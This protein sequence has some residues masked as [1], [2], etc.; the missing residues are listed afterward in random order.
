MKFFNRSKKQTTRN[1]NLDADAGGYVFRR[2]RTL[3]GTTSPKVASSASPRSQL[4]TARLQTHELHQLRNR[5][6][7][8]LAVL[9]I[10]IVILSWLVSTYVATVQIRSL[11]PGGKLA[12][13]DYQNTILDYK[14]PLERF[15]F[16]IN[17]KQLAS[18]MQTLHPEIASIDVDNNW[19]GGGTQ[20]VAQFR[21]PVLAWETGGKRFYVDAKG[22]AFQYDHFGGSYVSV[23]DQSGISPSVSGGTVASN[24]FIQFLGKMVGA[25]NTGGK[26]SVVEVIIPASTREADLKLQ[27][28]GYPIKTHIDRDPLQQAQDI[29]TT[30]KYFDDKKL[31]P[32]YVDV[33][34]AGKAFYK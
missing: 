16:A 29:L 25:V 13:T 9:V 6:L 18:D 23:S 34:V 12:T 21:R 7:R 17:R 22:V 15:G 4:K 33:R 11:Q 8:V 19:Y 1:P 5:V 3:T 27:G 20:F 28:R 26:G 24:R 30:L 32:Q 10:G 31:T 14:H 2:S